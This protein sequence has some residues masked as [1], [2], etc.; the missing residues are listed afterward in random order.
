MRLVAAVRHALRTIIAGRLF[1]VVI[2]VCLALG[3][4]TN[5]TMFSVFDAMFLRPLPFP[6][7][8]RLIAITGHHPDTNRRVTLSVDDI[9]ELATAGEPRR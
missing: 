5:T 9:N 7:P 4:A 6:D 1:T 3:I 8:E 2:L